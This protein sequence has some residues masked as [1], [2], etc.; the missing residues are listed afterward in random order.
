[1]AINVEGLT[2]DNRFSGTQAILVFCFVYEN[3]ATCFGY[4]Q[5]IAR[6]NSELRGSIE[7]GVKLKYVDTRREFQILQF[8]IRDTMKCLY[9]CLLYFSRRW[10]HVV[11]VCHTHV[12]S[13]LPFEPTRHS[14]KLSLCDLISCARGDNLEHH[15]A[16]LFAVL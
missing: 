15:T 16:C 14:H 11:C 12:Q 2:D 7:H 5:A 6:L 9:L 1:V 4:V 8:L 3:T 10:L 13:P